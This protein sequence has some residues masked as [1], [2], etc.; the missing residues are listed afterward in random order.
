MCRYRKK[1][2]FDDKRTCKVKGQIINWNKPFKFV[3]KKNYIYLFMH[4]FGCA[5]SQLWHGVS[6][7]FTVA[8]G[9]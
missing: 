8:R 3:F 6:L 9:I 5:W 7:N 1:N 2:F 4:F